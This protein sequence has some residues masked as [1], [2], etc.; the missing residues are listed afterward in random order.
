M[1]INAPDTVAPKYGFSYDIPEDGVTILIFFSPFCPNSQNLMKQLN[2]SP[3]LHNPWLK[4]IAVDAHTGYGDNLESFRNH[5]TP[6]AGDRIDYYYSYSNHIAFDYYFKMGGGH[7]ITWPLVMVVTDTSDAPVMRYG[8]EALTDLDKLEAILGYVSP[9]FAAWNG[10]IHD[11]TWNPATCQTPKT[12]S[13]CGTTEGEPLPHTWMEATC[14]APKTCSACGLTNGNALGH[15]WVAASCDAPKTCSVCGQTSGSALGHDWID[16]TCQLPKTC[17][18]CAATE[19]TV[20]PHDFQN[21]Y[22]TVCQLQKLVLGDADG[23][24]KLTYNDALKI[25]RASIKLEPLSPEVAQACD[26]DGNGRLDYNDALLV[27]RFSINLITE[28]PRKQ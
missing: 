24:G 22:C 12:C 6:D 7:T 23:N 13:E 20:A 18:R 26:V 16:A 8:A 14:D 3:W 27:L 21:G 28:F 25:L 4:V 17:S 1:E 2:N 9:A 19:G 15:T 5:F 10:D 11:H